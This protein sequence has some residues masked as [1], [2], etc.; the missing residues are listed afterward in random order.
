VSIL[1]ELEAELYNELFPS[2]REPGTSVQVDG[3]A[4]IVTDTRRKLLILVPRG[5]I[6]FAQTCEDS[7]P[8][9]TGELPDLSPREALRSFFSRGKAWTTLGDR[10][11]YGAALAVA[12]QDYS[13]G[14]GEFRFA[15]RLGDACSLAILARRGI[16]VAS[17]DSLP[18]IRSDHGGFAEFNASNG[19]PRAD[20]LA[21]ALAGVD[22]STSPRIIP[23]NTLE[24]YGVVS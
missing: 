15:S 6:S 2:M 22:S 20:S 11:I 12:R 23:I 18:T 14:I 13:N 10:S 9:E 5:P 24:S 16:R 4:A 1:H 8:S 17:R 7:Y 21:L 19:A 3:L